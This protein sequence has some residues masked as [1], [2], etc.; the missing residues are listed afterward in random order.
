[1]LACKVFPIVRSYGALPHT[2]RDCKEAMLLGDCI[3]AD[4]VDAYA[5]QVVNALGMNKWKTINYDLTPHSW[6][7]VAK[8]WLEFLPL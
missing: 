6:Q 1:M 3:T 4:E 7:N 8:S 2:L 5:A